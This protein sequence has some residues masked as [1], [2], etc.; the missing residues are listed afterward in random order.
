MSVVASRDS[1]VHLSGDHAALVRQF[2]H[3]GARPHVAI[4][5]G[6]HGDEWHSVLALLELCQELEGVE[7]SGRLTLVPAAHP[8]ALA[9]R[10][11]EAHTAPGD[12]NRLFLEEPR[13]EAAVLQDFAL[14][15]W[16]EYL[17]DANVLVDLHSGGIHDLIP[18]ARIQNGSAAVMPYVAAMGYDYAMVWSPFPKG[19]L[20]RTA[21]EAERI[22]FAVEEGPGYSL[23]RAYVTRIRQRV[24]GLLTASGLV[25]RLPTPTTK[26]RVVKQGAILEAA[27]PGFF[28]ASS[29]VGN[30]IQA[31]ALIGRFYPIHGEPA[32]TLHSP[33]S[34][35][36]FSQLL[37][38]P[39]RAG[40][41]L[42]EIVTDS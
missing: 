32:C 9:D 3:E 38:G 21:L 12:L 27:G 4:V 41:R 24:D 39:A 19:M 16:R 13:P 20:A 6:V 17:S 34:G 1:Y 29:S 5:A 18:H 42:V 15:L 26:P 35:V 7:L 11:R 37:G 36:I 22:S 10:S 25:G 30:E 14:Q 33:A 8:A 40:E 28:E 23:E 2:G 31:E